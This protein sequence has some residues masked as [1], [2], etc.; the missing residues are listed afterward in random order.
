MTEQADLIRTRRRR[1]AAP[2][3]FHDKLVRTLAVALPAGVGVLFAVMLL[4]PLSPRGEISFLLDRTKVAVVEDRLKVES[5]MYRG[6]DDAGRPFSI[7]AGSAVQHSAENPVVTMNDLVARILLS[8]GP[9][10]LTAG[11]GNYDMAD[12]R[13]RVFGPVVFAAAD[14]Y[15]MT[16][17]NV[18]IDIAAKRMVSRGPVEGHVPAG[19]FRA[20]RIVTDLDARTVTLDGNARLRMTPGRMK[21]P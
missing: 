11:T 16:A 8:R 1:F 5:A 18:D 13:V 15:R 12:K 7:T 2:G 20:D 17:E 4:A 9:G 14:G 21:M 19:T 10:V 3:G 6:Q